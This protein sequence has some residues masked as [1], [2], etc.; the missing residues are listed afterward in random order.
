MQVRREGRGGRGLGLRVRAGGAEA[1]SI[2]Q[3]RR[4]S[5]RVG[6]VQASGT[7][8][9]GAAAGQ[10][11]LHPALSEHQ[12]TQGQGLGNKA[13]QRRG[14]HPT[15]CV[16]QP[17]SAAAHSGPSQSCPYSARVTFSALALRIPER[18]P[19]LSVSGFPN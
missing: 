3:A 19:R 4:R 10:P 9:R 11:T 14:S 17:S 5:A 12:P 2:S 6:G 7:W 15:A 8:S 13:G 16:A 1:E 18:R